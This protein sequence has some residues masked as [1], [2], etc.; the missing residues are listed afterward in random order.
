MTRKLTYGIKQIVTP[1]VIGDLR[2]VLFEHCHLAFGKI[3]IN[4]SQMTAI[5]NLPFKCFIRPLQPDHSVNSS[6]LAITNNQSCAF[7]DHS[8]VFYL[9][10]VNLYITHVPRISRYQESFNAIVHRNSVCNLTQFFQDQHRTDSA[11]IHEI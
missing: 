2:N 4:L 9:L 5:A 6:D 7:G 1:E 10:H 8:R 3:Q 11:K